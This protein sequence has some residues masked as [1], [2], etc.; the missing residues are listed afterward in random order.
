[1][2]DDNRQLDAISLLATNPFALLRRY[3]MISLVALLVTVVILLFLYRQGELAEHDEIAAESSKRASIHFV[4]RLGAQIDTL[5]T[6]SNGL[7]AKAL[8][9]N[10][11]NVVLADAPE[12]ARDYDVIK[13]KIYSPSGL[14]IYSSDESE[15]GGTTRHPELLAK[16]LS[17]QEVSQ[18]E[19]HGAFFGLT[20]QIRD[21]NVVS[22]YMVLTQAGN[23]IGVIET[24][25]DETPFVKEIFSNTI[26]MPLSVL[27][28]FLM[29]Y[30]VL[31]LFLLRHDRAADIWQKS[32]AR[33]IT[34]RLKVEADQRISAI[35]FE[36]QEGI[37]IAD[38]NN[39]VLRVNDAFT[40]TTGYAAEE[41]IGKN[42]NILGFDGP[43]AN[44]E[45][46]MGKC[47]EK[48]GAW[49][50]E[51]QTRCKNGESCPEYLNVTAVKD[52]K[53]GVTNYVVSFTNLTV[54]N[55]AADKIKRLAFYDPLTGLP[56]RRLLRD[57]LSRAFASTARSGKEG[58]L[59]FIDLDNFKAL[60]DSLGHDV[61]DLLLQQTAQRLVSCTRECDTVARL[62][63]DEFVVMLE[64]LS[65]E[66]VQAATQTED[67][68]NKIIAAINRSYL[69]GTL[70]YGS[71]ASIGAVMFSNHGQSGE[72]LLKHADIAMYQAKKAGRNC[73]RFFNQEMQDI[74][75]TRI[76]VEG[77][78]R[79]AL[80]SDQFELHYQVQMDSSHRPLGAEALIRWL[81][82]ERGL[83]SPGQFI[84]LAEETG[85]ILPI[86]QW[87][88]NAA[89]AQ[90]KTWE[91]DVLTRGLVLAVNVSAR[92][93]RQTDFVAQVQAALQRHGIN[94]TLL[95]VELTESM[96]LEN[97]EDT[98]A[99]MKELKQIGVRFSLD[100]FG[101][102]YSSL[103]YIKRLPLDQLKIDQSFV[104][105]IATD[106]SDKAI[107]RTIIAMAQSLNLD[108]IAEGVETE[109]QRQRLL[110]M[111]CIH[112][113]GY[114]LGKPV[115]IETFDALLNTVPPS[116]VS[117]DAT[118]EMCFV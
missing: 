112:Y 47:I 8:Q 23:R 96:L 83:V 51:M 108:I 76:A 103:Q 79:K 35:A 28:A 37:L 67:V 111:G 1:M 31:Y 59:L 27:A 90:L 80:Q 45:A 117:V 42:I 13:V 84:P 71:T 70:K 62:G 64:D 109:D 4:R 63:G 88:L 32:M 16:A 81:H 86:G 5:I 106:S 98:I 24:D 87:V 20:G 50:G 56:N 43:D 41:I 21:V 6:A 12:V 73:L 49:E 18:H 22:T 15:I 34:E 48:T 97:I 100:D 2:P 17:G 72:E 44:F 102:G 85:L 3:S 104:R 82:P 55:E 14:V 78:L 105:D 92:Q 69:L 75:D 74:I 115:P 65:Q 54:I 10:Q 52:D 93:F 101:T 39:E 116:R 114:L 95:K 99:T 26:E 66:P 30:A 91:R 25:M 33:N 38:A 58:A 61:G 46:E 60:N 118:D 40:K 77:E 68:G 110:E 11:D 107:V 53:G 29:L 7:G 36:S 94:P 89:C 57:R 9:A 113:Q 19:L